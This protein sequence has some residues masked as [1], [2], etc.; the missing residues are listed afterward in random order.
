MTTL[1][2]TAPSNVEV[3]NYLWLVACVVCD[4]CHTCL[5]C[6][7]TL[8]ISHGALGC[9]GT[10]CGC[11]RATPSPRTAVQVPGLMTFCAP[12]CSLNYLLCICCGV[13]RGRSP[14]GLC[15]QRT[16][17]SFVG[18]WTVATLVQLIVD[19]GKCAERDSAGERGRAG[20]AQ[21]GW[22]RACGDG[23]GQLGSRQTLTIAGCQRC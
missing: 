8:S 22:R 20:T 2:K 11:C 6:P 18:T 13:G 23:P 10:C 15:P 17:R 19:L 16:R 14:Y 4:I 9:L 1:E 7:K 12:Q 21:D 3:L 5:C